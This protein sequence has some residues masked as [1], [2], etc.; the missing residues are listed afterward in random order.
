MSKS[1]EGFGVLVILFLILSAMF[2]AFI[3]ISMYIAKDADVKILVEKLAN[4][5]CEVIST[6]TECVVATSTHTEVAT[7]T[8][9]VDCS[10]TESAYNE[11]NSQ[12][13]FCWSQ[14]NNSCSQE[15]EKLK[16]DA[17]SLLTGRD[18]CREQL[19]SCYEEKEA[20]KAKLP[21]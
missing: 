16:A 10:T 3:A 2:T 8:S 13:S 1:N 20:C 6:T 11:L 14:N 9:E 5:N 4:A 7:T 15:Y 12:L 21:W 17:F 19:S 18:K